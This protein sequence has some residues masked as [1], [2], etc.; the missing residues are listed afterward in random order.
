M[1]GK[2]VKPVK[3]L[4][5]EVKIDFRW[6]ILALLITWSLA[7]GLF[8]NHYAGLSI[9]AYWVMGIAGTLGFFVSVVLHEP[10]QVSLR[11]GQNRITTGGEQ[12]TRRHVSFVR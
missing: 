7:R 1:F 4:G 11:S 6:L 8:P 2:G 3:L 10:A 9:T 12:H 5:F